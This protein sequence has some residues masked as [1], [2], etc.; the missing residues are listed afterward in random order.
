MPMSI[1]SD[2]DLPG[3]WGVGGTAGLEPGACLPPTHFPLFGEG[4][5]VFNINPNPDAR[6]RELL[7]VRALGDPR[8]FEELSVVIVTSGGLK[9]RWPLDADTEGRL[10]QLFDLF[11]KK[12]DGTVIELPLPAD[13]SL[14]EPARTG[15]PSPRRVGQHE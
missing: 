1:W 8:F 3:W 10:R 6:P 5:R 14:P 7:A 4:C 11:K 9:A 2:E 12:S 13:L 15:I